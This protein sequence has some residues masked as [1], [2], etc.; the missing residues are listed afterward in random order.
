M[1]K[2]LRINN[3]MIVKESDVFTIH[4]PL[5]SVHISLDDTQEV[6]DFMKKHLDIANFKSK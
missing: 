4:D 5:G 1:A 3:I 2:E 6:I